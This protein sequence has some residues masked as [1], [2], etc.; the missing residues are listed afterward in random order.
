[1][2]KLLLPL[3]LLVAC[4]RPPAPKDRLLWHVEEPWISPPAAEGTARIARATIVSF[5]GDGK[6][7]EHRCRL[8]ERPD[9]AVY[10]A[11]GQPEVVVTGRWEQRGAS[12]NVM[13]TKIGGTGTCGARE[14]R[15]QIDGRS[16]VGPS[17]RFSPMTRLVAPDYDSRIERAEDS[18]RA[19]G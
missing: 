16:V 11:S 18:S 19:C 12:I 9:Q 15:F 13:R 1:M 8:I 5:H 10:I 17:G 14:I 6:Y 2:R 4:S 7:V 3:L